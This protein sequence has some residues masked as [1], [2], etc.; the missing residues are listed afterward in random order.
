MSNGSNYK[1]SIPIL[2]HLPHT[3]NAPVNMEKIN[4][5]REK[6]KDVLELNNVD[7]PY[8]IKTSTMTL[9]GKFNTTF[10]P[11]NIFRYIKRSKNGI[12]NVVKGNSKK[13]KEKDEDLDVDE[14][15]NVIEKKPVH[16]IPKSKARKGKKSKNRQS[17]VFLN[18]VT[19]SINVSN[20]EK[21]V[22][23]KI[24]NNGTVHFTGCVTI[25]N[26]L[27][28]TYKLCNECCRDIAVLDENKKIKDIKFV[29]DP[30]ILRV[31]NLFDNKVD[32]I[33]CIFVA[34]F[35]IDRPKLQVLMKADGYNAV[36]DS[37]GH[38]GVK[39]K[40]VSTGQKITIFVFESGSIIII[41]GK[42]GFSRI[43]EIFTFIY[44]YLL[45]NYESIVKEDGIT[46]S[47]ILDFLAKEKEEEEKRHQAVLN[48]E[49][50]LNESKYRN[51]INVVHKEMDK[52]GQKRGRPRINKDYDLNNLIDIAD[53]EHAINTKKSTTLPI[54]ASSKSR[55]L[56]N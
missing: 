5:L 15:G 7:I 48:A 8:D 10:Y 4:I 53:I 11:Y 55:L 51:A 32:M 37:N 1:S 40:Y 3:Q 6:I 34:P 43:N 21:P 56:C 12:I 49:K 52:Q 17:D 38:A 47:V 23:V 29:E 25:D 20:K 42:Q 19:V 16:H 54:N 46:T 36:Y 14:A 28:A 30:D 2:T 33:N 18:Q 35:K 22:S 24:F 9:E 44:K 41:L 27:E 45:E 39:I 26:L 50:I 31:E 13:K